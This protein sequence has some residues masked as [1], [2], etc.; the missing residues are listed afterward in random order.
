MRLFELAALLV[1]EATVQLVEL[2]L[3]FH[4]DDSIALCW[5]PLKDMIPNNEWN[6]AQPLFHHPWYL[7]YQ[8]Y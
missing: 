8:Q 7:E 2:E 6:K 4:S 1:D 5:R 3:M